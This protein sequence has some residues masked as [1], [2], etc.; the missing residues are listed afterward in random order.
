MKQV[1]EKAPPTCL[2]RWIEGNRESLY[3]PSFIAALFLVLTAITWRKWG[4]I[5][6]DLP[7]HLYTPWRLSLGEVLYRDVSNLHG[8]F[9]ETFHGLLFLLFGSSVNTLVGAS[10][11]LL[12]GQCCLLYALF[13]KEACSLIATVICS[14]FLVAFAFAHLTPNGN[15]NFILSYNYE[16]IHG[17]FFSTCALLFLG[18]WSDEG[19]LREAALAGLF[20]GLAALTKQEVTLALG[21]AIGAG[22]LLAWKNGKPIASPVAC[23]VGSAMGPGLL[24]FGFFAVSL[25]AAGALR[26]LIWPWKALLFSGASSNAFHRAIL[27]L[28]DPWE[29]AAATIQAAGLGGIL[30]LLLLVLCHRRVPKII[31][32]GAGILSLWLAWRCDWRDSGRALPLFSLVVIGVLGA[33][34][35]S[36]RAGSLFPLVWAVFGLGFLAKMGINCRIW[37]YGYVLAMPASLGLIFFLLKTLPD[38]AELHGFDGKRLRILLAAL[39]SVG[40]LQLGTD[41]WENYRVKTRPFGSGS[42]LMFTGDFAQA[43]AIGLSVDWLR[44]NTPPEATLVALPQGVILNYLARRPNPT[45]YLTWIVTEYNTFGEARLLGTLQ[46]KAPD[47]IALVHTDTSEYGFRFFGQPGY[48]EATMRWIGANYR[49]IFL[50]GHEPFTGRQFGIRLLK[51]MEPPRPFIIPIAPRFE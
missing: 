9:S 41:S 45:P 27:G 51:R 50:A 6:V 8:P 17:L 3:G 24:F 23:F 49:P 13:R 19:R 37:H 36:G 40:T 26:V 10:L 46:A 12:A 4:E 25:G 29:N 32:I 42:D 18:R 47:Y 5:L 11:L 20:F 28:D 43:E 35:L 33:Q 30:V 21:L 31:Q 7:L 38:F 14:V 48:A 22:F 16:L 15:Y 44:R 1:S 2:I 39:I 34:R